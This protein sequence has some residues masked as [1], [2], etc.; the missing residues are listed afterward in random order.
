[1]FSDKGE[2]TKKYKNPT[3]E[4][5]S[6]SFVNHYYYLTIPVKANYYLFNSG[7]LKFYID[8]GIGANIFVGEKTVA[9]NTSS[10]NTNKTINSNNSGINNINWTFEG[11]CGINYNFNEKSGVKIEPIYRRSL[12]AATNTPIKEYLYS[13]G[14]N[15]GLFTTF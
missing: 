6:Y 7:K 1:M 12:S 4:N 5:V 9:L 8:A 10:N 11:G 15:I 13:G 3:L 2:Q 14:L